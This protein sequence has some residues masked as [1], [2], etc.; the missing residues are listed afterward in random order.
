MN[1]YFESASQYAVICDYVVG[2]MLYRDFQGLSYF[3][4]AAP[5]DHI[6]LA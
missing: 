1:G 3:D 5:T 4:G 6:S 2:A